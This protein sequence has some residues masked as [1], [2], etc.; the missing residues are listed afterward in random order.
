MFTR[1]AVALACAAALL[2]GCGASAVPGGGAYSGANASSAYQPLSFISPDSTPK[3]KSVTPIQA[4]QTQEIQIKG[5][6]FG[7]MKPYNGDSCC[8]KIVVTNPACQYYYP[9]ADTWQAGY[10][11]SGNDVTL[12]VTKWS[13]KKIVLAGFTGLYGDYCWYLVA[14]YGIQINVWNAQKQT[15]P[16]TWNGTVQ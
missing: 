4:E 11:G 7:K 5:T 15:G 12:N 6:G 10:E 13:N 2:A 8:I 14:N 3:I 16:A 1:Q 9:Y